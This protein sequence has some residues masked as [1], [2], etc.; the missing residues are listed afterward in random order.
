MAASNAPQAATVAR[1]GTSTTSAQLRTGGAGRSCYVYNESA[2]VLSILYGTGTASAT[3]YTLKLAANTG[4][5]IEGF[6][7]PL[8]GILDTGTGNAQITTW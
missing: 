6:G 3:N 7:G 8:Q 2:G 5:L 1:P 4:T